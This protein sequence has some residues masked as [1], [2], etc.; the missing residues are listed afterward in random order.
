VTLPR[1]DLSVPDVALPAWAVP[2]PEG[3]P[4]RTGAPTVA[5]DRAA[6]SV[7]VERVLRAS[8]ARP[9]DAAL[10]AHTLVLS[11]ARGHPSHGVSRL[12]QY[13]RLIDSGAVDA[14]ARH[15]VTARRAAL[16]AWDARYG[17]GPAVGVRAMVRAVAMARRAGIGAVVVR[18]AG[19]F[20]QAGAYVLRALEAG[21]VGIS[22]GNATPGMAPVGGAAPGLG[23]NP[24]AIGAPDG[25][26]RG[27]LLDMATSV[28]AVGKVEVAR[29]AGRRIPAGWGV[30]A[31]GQPTTDPAAVLE[32]GRML[33]LG[34]S[35]ETAGYKGYGLASA[36]DILTGM[37]GGGSFGLAVTGLWDTGRPT[38]SSQLHIAIDPT[39]ADGSDDRSAF[40]AR[41]RAWRD[42]QTSLARAPDVPEILVAGE[43]EWR[44]DERQAMRIDLLVDV[45]RDLATLAVE[46]RLLRA[47][48]AVVGAAS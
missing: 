24:I 34:G 8:G 41:L 19:H 6:L 1:V 39:G 36:V 2:A 23:T 13:V 15:V 45:V 43:L 16:E 40:A 12:R 14:R 18:D 4:T 32:G 38:T 7:F 22:M 29:R 31:D 20:G 46:R 37:L 10:T 44:A 47:W 42:E 9:A 28:V 17:L 27:F 33:P 35:A 48:R 25:E 3:E 21:M 11:D 26:G 30:D 5:V